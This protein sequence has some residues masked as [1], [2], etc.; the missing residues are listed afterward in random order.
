[1]QTKAR[2]KRVRPT[3]QETDRHPADQRRLRSPRYQRNGRGGFRAAPSRRLLA[4]EPINLV[5]NASRIGALPSEGRIVHRTK[6]GREF[7]ASSHEAPLGNAAAIARYSNA[8]S[9]RVGMA[10]RRVAV[11][12]VTCSLPLGAR[13]NR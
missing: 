3:A 8:V 4:Q 2:A 10:V 12:A 13:T 11:T 5:I 7:P 9:Q 6:I 1:M